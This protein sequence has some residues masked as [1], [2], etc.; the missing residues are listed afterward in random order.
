MKMVLSQSAQLRLHHVIS[1]FYL[2]GFKTTSDLIRDMLRL[3]IL[4]SFILFLNRIKFI[5]ISRNMSRINRINI[6]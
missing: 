1:E 4:I 3:L 2:S 6:T 5:K